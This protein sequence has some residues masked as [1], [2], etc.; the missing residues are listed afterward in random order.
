MIATSGL[1]KTCAGLGGDC[2]GYSTRRTSLHCKLHCPSP[3]RR[4]RNGFFG[5]RYA[6]AEDASTRVGKCEFASIFLSGCK[7]LML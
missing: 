6:L 1:R 2:A 5:S 7:S 4:I 3:P